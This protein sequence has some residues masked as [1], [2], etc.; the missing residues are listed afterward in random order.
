MDEFGLSLREGS[1]EPSQCYARCRAMGVGGIAMLGAAMAMAA[2]L[3]VGC[4]GKQSRSQTPD[5]ANVSTAQAPGGSSQKRAAKK[6]IVRKPVDTVTILDKLITPRVRAMVH[7]EKLRTHP[8]GPQLL[9]TKAFQRLTTKLLAPAG[10]DALNDIT[11][12]YVVSTGLEPTATSAAVLKHT[13]DKASL[14]ASID[15]LVQMSEPP[16][17]WLDTAKDRVKVSSALVQVE[18]QESLLV[19]GRNQLLIAL[20]PDRVDAVNRF[21]GPLALRHF[22]PPLEAP[23]EKATERLSD[24]LYAV[25]NDPSEAF[26]GLNG[27]RI[28]ETIGSFAVRVVLRDDGGADVHASG[29]STSEEQAQQDAAAL[30]QA[31]ESAT[32]VRLG[33]LRIRM[34]RRVVF[35]AKGRRV[36]AME[37]LTAKELSMLIGYANLAT[38]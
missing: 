30:T 25:V 10:I 19:L 13:R 12:L 17:R 27:L 6:P 29:L 2:V 32:S 23:S 22:A 1:K 16:G 14:E 37:A 8:V 34:F 18:G 7:L 15:K 21:E 33:A 11:T 5:E 3:A 31:I 28:P 4:A 36:E 35:A 24:T 38:R 9:R 20:P 26:K